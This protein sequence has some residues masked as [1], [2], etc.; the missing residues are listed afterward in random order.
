MTGKQIDEINKRYLEYCKNDV[1][2]LYHVPFIIWLKYHEKIYPKD[3]YGTIIK[4]TK[5]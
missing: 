3:Y 2:K 1:H 5:I 4:E